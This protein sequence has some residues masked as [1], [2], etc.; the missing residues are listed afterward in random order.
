[1]EQQTLG[2]IVKKIVSL[3]RVRMRKVE[4]IKHVTESDAAAPGGDP[5]IYSLCKD[6]FR[7]LSES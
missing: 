4:D 3:I 5:H 6:R 2:T 7:I 1:M